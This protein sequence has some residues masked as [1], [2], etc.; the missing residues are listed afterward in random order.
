MLLYYLN[1]L[2]LW[3]SDKTLG[4]PCI[5]SLL[6]NLFNKWASAWDFQQF[7][8]IRAFASRLN[9]LWLL[10]YWLNTVWSF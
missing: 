4:K 10:S 8:M 6:L 3:K 1:L 2:N 5:L 9:I 7:G